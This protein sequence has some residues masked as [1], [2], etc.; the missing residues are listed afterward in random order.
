[1][2]IVE[3]FMKGEEAKMNWPDKLFQNYP[4]FYFAKD[5]KADVK[6]NSEE[7]NYIVRPSKIRRIV[8]SLFICFGLFFWITILIMIFKKELLPITLIFLLLITCW[9]GMIA[10]TFFLSPKYSYKITFNNH[11][12]IIGKEAIKWERISE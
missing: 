6:K 9:I 3:E 1:M 11:E 5:I 2:N 7:R 8:A 4:V 10:R 12:I